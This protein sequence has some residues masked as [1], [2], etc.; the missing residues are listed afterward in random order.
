MGSIIEIY[1]SDSYKI[2]IEEIGS[3][4]SS[5][6]YE[7]YKNSAIHIKN[8]IENTRE[9]HERKKTIERIGINSYEYKKKFLDIENYNN[10]IAFTGERGTGKSSAMA[11]FLE[12]LK[13]SSKSKE[14]N[15]KELDDIQEYDYIFLDT[16]DPTIFEEDENL[17]GII[18]AKMFSKF[19]DFAEVNMDIEKKKI[20]I[21]SFADVY[22]NMRVLNMKQKEIL[23]ENIYSETS[24]ETLYRLA[25]G[26]NMRES[27]IELVNSLIPVLS[28]HKDITKS[29]LVIS[30]D[31]LDMNVMHAEK[32][33][34]QIRKYV[35]I[36]NIIIIMAVK[37]EQLTDIV[38]QK[39]IQ[40]FKT[41]ID[42]EKFT[43]DTK[44]MAIRYMEKLIPPQRRMAMP[45]LMTID[46]GRPIIKI[47]GEKRQ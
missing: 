21:N 43:E 29:F 1:K 14:T 40:N 7:L 16:I 18:I 39:Y 28:K 15:M 35:I 11:S 4:K 12:A 13:Y 8:I 5:I 46:N 20:I 33:I 36:P 32:M 22:E 3:L 26:S 25:A 34:E 10:I 38:E 41:M 24:I 19:K 30:I 27:F 9:Y 37:I 2:K 45:N 31:D 42:K 44:L 6:F 47:I 17:F 23:K